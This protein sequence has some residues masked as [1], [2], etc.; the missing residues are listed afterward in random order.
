MAARGGL[1]RREGGTGPNGAN[2]LRSHSQ[3]FMSGT[4]VARSMTMDWSWPPVAREG[5]GDDDSARVRT[6]VENGVG[7]LVMDR[8]DRRNALDAA[9]R[10]ALLSALAKWQ[11]DA[12][13]RVVVMSG[14]GKTF[15][16]G[17]DLR[18][19]L[20]RTPEEQR[21]FVT[22]PHIFSTIAD[23]PVPVIACVNGHAFGAG[24]E[25][26]AACDL[27]VASTGAKMGQPEINLGLIP[28][29]GGTQ[30]LPRLVGYGRAMRMV[31]TGDAVDG[32]EAQRIGLVDE[33]V[34]ADGLHA[35]VKELAEGIAAKSPVAVR[36]AKAAMR[37]A[38]TKPLDEGLAHE[39]DAFMEAF[40]SAEA[41]EGISAFIE[42]RAPDF[43]KS[44]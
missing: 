29:G 22:P 12:S 24:C 23:Y 30:R 11:G 2:L 4:T 5:T 38:W 8:P 10:E 26:L 21:A 17:A 35:R 36:A 14:I 42:R 31:L 28:G 19:M 39:V 16:A 44:S 7:Y 3:A 18:E 9:M 33:A 20:A 15:A 32:A 43:S 34:D 1:R 27:R 41:R 25:L 13:V 40:A 6:H 37:A